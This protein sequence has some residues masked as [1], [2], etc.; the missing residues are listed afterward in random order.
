ML[1][2]SGHSKWATIHRQKEITDAKRGAVW[3]KI[4]NAIIVAVRETGIGD[5]DS[6]FKLRMAMDKGRAANMPNEN[7]KRAIEKGLGASSSGE[8]WEE[9]TY[10]GFGP[11]GVAIMVEVATDNNKRSAQEIKNYL[12]KGGGKLVGPGGVAF[13]FKRVGM[14]IIDNPGSAEETM[15]KLIDL[16][17]EDV[18]EADG[19]IE[20]YT[21]PGDL[22]TVKQAVLQAGYKINSFELVY[23]P[24]TVVTINDKEEAQKVL[25]FIEG[26]EEL[27]DVQKVFSNLDIPQEVLE[28]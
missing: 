18:E 8:Q 16:G 21:Q 25:S 3:T 12:E 28:N 4:T 1:D 15:L 24:T 22:E 17:A 5:P 6:N 14:L 20:I 27:S 11:H 19:V 10:E 23:K 2:M 7:I 26:L 9:I 13:Q